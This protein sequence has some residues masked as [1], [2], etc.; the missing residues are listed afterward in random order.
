MDLLNKELYMQLY[1]KLTITS[2][3]TKN[4]ALYT[5]STLH[6]HVVL[7]DCLRW[8]ETDVSELRP[9]WAFC[10]SPGDLRRGL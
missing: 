4:L 6:Y 9:L 7:V 8:G 5:M 1:M 3:V 2:A 10:S